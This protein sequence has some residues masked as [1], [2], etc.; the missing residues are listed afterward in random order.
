MD[1]TKKK[2][3]TVRPTNGHQEGDIVELTDDEVANYNGGETE[4]RFVLCAEE[5]AEAKAGE[6]GEGSQSGDANTAGE[7]DQNTPK[8]GDVCTLEDGTEGTLKAGEDGVLV[9]TVKPQE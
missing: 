9:C 3:K 8:E 5:G 7:G 1:E 2:Y 4:P 6:G